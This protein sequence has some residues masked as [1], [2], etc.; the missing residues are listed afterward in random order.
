M[1]IVSRI[2]HT[3]LK[4]E[5]D[6]GAI[7]ALCAEATRH[8]F[9][10]VCVNGRFVSRVAKHLGESDVKPCAVVGFPLGAGKA[11]VEA[12]E[13]TSA[14]KDGAQEIDFV[15]PLPFLLSR[16]LD[17]ARGHFMEIVKSARAVRAS[18][19]VKVIIESAL[20]MRDVSAD[21]AEARIALACQ[22]ARESG[23]DFVKSS[24]GFHPAGGASLAAVE[25]MR[26]HA[27]PLSVKAAGGIRSYADAQAMVDAGADR[28]GCSAGVAIAEAE[29][30]AAAI[31]DG[32]SA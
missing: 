26:K 29:R 21:E 24:T 22:A 14:C 23:C 7:D 2:D 1:S 9:A 10:A 27:G 32:K 8:G 16:S 3:N 13:A 15:A 4:P 25:L 17:E 20:L 6:T 31:G 19:I 28:I 12:I 30:G 11:T 18:V 5:S